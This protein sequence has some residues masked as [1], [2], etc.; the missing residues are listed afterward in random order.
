MTRVKRKWK[1]VYRAKGIIT[2]VNRFDISLFLEI[3]I[4]IE[5]TIKSIR[6]RYPFFKTK[7][8]G[9]DDEV[10]RIISAEYSVKYCG[11][12]IRMISL[13]QVIMQQGQ[14]MED[15]KIKRILYGITM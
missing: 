1:I 4:P 2:N 3:N 10:L 6:E 11:K 15:G 13:L 8:M 14:R 9:I 5:M 7:N 12:I